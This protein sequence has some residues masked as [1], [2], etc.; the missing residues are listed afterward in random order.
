MVTPELQR[1]VEQFLYREARLLDGG[2]LAEWL[3]LFAEDARYWMPAR[4]T[5]MNRAEE[6]R[7]EGELA[8]FDDDKNFLRARIERIGGGLAHAEEP[9]SRTRHFVSNIEVREADGGEI[10]ALSNILV[11]QSR[12]ERTECTYVGRR[13]DRLRRDGAGFKIAR[14]TIVLDQTLFPRTISVFF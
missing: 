10:E 5:R 14:R 11:Y 8:I 1:E 4:E 7:G 3:D 6:L 2:K 12:L 9:P 13:E